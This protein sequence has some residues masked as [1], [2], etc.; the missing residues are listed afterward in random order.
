MERMGHI[1]GIYIGTVLSAQQR[2]S[3][4]KVYKK[5]KIHNERDTISYPLDDYNQDN[6]KFGQGYEKLEPSIHCW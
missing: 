6:G 3:K 5:K 2:D 4:S 1:R